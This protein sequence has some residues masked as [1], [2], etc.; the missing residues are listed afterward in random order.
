MPILTIL[1]FLA[2][3]PAEC[4][5]VPPVIILAAVFG[6]SL[7]LRQ[8]HLN[9]WREIAARTG[10][11]LEPGWIGASPQV[12][13]EYRGRP[14]TMTSVSRPRGSSSLR[15]NW[16]RVTLRIQN[17]TFLRLKLSREDILDRLA[18]PLLK[19]IQVGDDAFDRHFLVQPDEPE[20]ARVVLNDPLLR[21][22]LIQIGVYNVDVLN[23]RLECNYVGLEKDPGHA[24]VVFNAL[25]DLADRI[26]QAQP[27]ERREILG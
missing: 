18:A 26:D 13:G 7:F 6:V 27:V 10:L 9:A 5:L 24:G 8:L 17:P 14:L 2:E 3:L 22:D 12:R 23:D 1:E 15:K 4:W 16:T 20:V 11:T 25:S 19:D 21:R